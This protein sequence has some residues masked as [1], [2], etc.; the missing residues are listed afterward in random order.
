MTRKRLGMTAVV[1]SDG[2]VMGI[3]TDGDL[4]RTLDR[5][6]DPRATPVAEV[7]TQGGK[8]IDPEALAAEA[9]QL[10]QEHRIQAL[11]V[12]DPDGSLAG[13]LNFQDL[14]AAGVV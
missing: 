1:G 10:M 7:M 5:G 12:L 8:S 3:F 4:R 14:L 13:V 6:L 9:A 11:L 2:Q